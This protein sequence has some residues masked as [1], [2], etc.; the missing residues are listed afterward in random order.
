[1]RKYQVRTDLA[2]EARDMYIEKEEREEVAGVKVT[3]KRFKDIQITY[4]N[5]SE[6]GEMKVGKKAGN[7]ITVYSNQMENQD[8]QSQEE[9]TTVLSKE[10]QAMLEKNLIQDSDVGLVVGL[11]NENVTPD[12]LGPIT[13]EKI[14][15]TSHLFQMEGETVEKGYR[16]VAAVTPGV[17]GVT[18]IETSEIVRGIINKFSPDFVVAVD[19]LASRST[20]RLNK[21]IQISDTGIQPGSGVGNNRKELSQETLG[22]PVISIGVPTVVDAVTITSDTIDYLLKHLGKEYK[23]IDKSFQSLLPGGMSFGSKKL[24]DKDMPDLKQRETFLG[25]VGTLNEEEKRTLIH[26]VLTPLG[27]NMFV[28]PK[29]VDHLMVDIGHILASSINAALHKN[30]PLNKVTS[31]TR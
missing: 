9:I 26:D 11:G 19:A 14:L 20:E 31:Y 27:K 4:V 3:K 23:E 12:A 2:I 24:S 10:L 28:A 1:M 21:T 16:S 25:I 15:V 30:V 17:M 8:T 5:I 18:G 6:Q 29:E 13:L 22:I 7:Y